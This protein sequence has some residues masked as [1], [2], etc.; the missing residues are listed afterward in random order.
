MTWLL[1]F[2]TILKQCYIYIVVFFPNTYLSSLFISF[3]L[4]P[5]LGFI[6]PSALKLS[7]E[8]H[9]PKNKT[10]LICTRSRIWDPLLL[11]TTLPFRS[12]LELSI[13]ILHLDQTLRS[14]LPLHFI[15]SVRCTLQDF[16]SRKSQNLIN[17]QVA[18]KCWLLPRLD[19]R[20]K[21]KKKHALKKTRKNVYIRTAAGKLPSW[22]KK[23]QPIS[24]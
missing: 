17:A 8:A 12:R 24:T 18:N 22:Y 9:F 15:S 3:V 6:Y 21:K 1:I 23:F 19:R 10:S 14:S 2:F 13:I 5:L 7:E 20:L 4:T 11:T 16:I